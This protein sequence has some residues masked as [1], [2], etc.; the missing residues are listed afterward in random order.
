MSQIFQKKMDL[1]I[2]QPVTMAQVSTFNPS[3][4]PGYIGGG[5]WL[6]NEYWFVFSDGI[7]CSFR[8]SVNWFAEQDIDDLARYCGKDNMTTNE[9][10]DLARLSFKKLDYKLLPTLLDGP[11]SHMEG[12]FDVKKLG[13]IPYCRVTWSS[14][15]ATTREEEYEHGYTIRFD[16]DMQQ[17]QVVGMFMVGK[18]FWRPE[19]KIDVTP[20]LES[21]FKKQNSGKMF[22]RS[23][24]PP[25][26]PISNTPLQKK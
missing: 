17:K 25:P 21:D 8:S 10:V 13:H 11:P 19:P 6:T 1:P 16:V 24:A 3:I 23:N 22:I 15:K 2:P 5:L 18:R 4:I 7:V 12:P 9:V 14:P 26:Q 20:L